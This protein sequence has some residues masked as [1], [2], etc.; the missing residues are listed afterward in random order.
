[1]PRGREVDLGRGPGVTR[2]G[3]PG[4][5]RASAGGHRPAPPVDDDVVV[6]PGTAGERRAC[7]PSV[8]SLR[9]PSCEAR[10]TR[11]T[12]RP[13]PAQ[14]FLQ[15][16]PPQALACMAHDHSTQRQPPRLRW[17]PRAPACSLAYAGEIS[18]VGEATS[19]DVVSSTPSYL[20]G[21]AGGHRIQLRDGPGRVRSAARTRWRGRH[22]STIRATTSLIRRRLSLNA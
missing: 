7:G 22:H 3:R 14:D 16:G 8:R 10:P 13:W 17:C 5:L 20:R 15:W 2:R 21:G 19:R 18:K 12:R 4:D 11:V 1:V 9:P 6:H